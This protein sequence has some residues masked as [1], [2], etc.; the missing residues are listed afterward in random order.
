MTA[1]RK[2]IRIAG[3][4]AAVYSGYAA[5]S[6]FRYGRAGRTR[7]RPDPLDRYLP[8]AEVTERHSI[9]VNAPPDVVYE[10]CRKFDMMKSPAARLLFD[11]RSFLMCGG[12]K[13]SDL[14]SELIEQVTSVGWELLEET[15]GREF[16]FGSAAKPWV[17]DAGF[18]AVP[19]S[20]FAAF[21]E[22]GWAK[23]VWNLSVSPSATGC[24][25]STETRVSTTDPQARKLFRRYWALASPGVKVIRLVSLRTIK[26]MAEAKVAPK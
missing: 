17:A 12:N 24:T 19:P 1:I 6:W 3:F 16:I 7:T 20:Q 9:D 26:R 21:R 5:L 8:D 22:P 4:G 11:L 2:A 15:P 25:V 13:E 14:P 23:I 18:R 10:A